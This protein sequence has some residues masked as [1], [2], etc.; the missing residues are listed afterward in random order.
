[1]KIF[2]NI[3]TTVVLLLSLAIGCANP[4]NPAGAGSDTDAMQATDKQAFKSALEK[5]LKAVSQKDLS[6]L[7]GTLSPKGDMYLVLPRSPITT[8]AKE[9]LATH[10]EW[11]QDTSW[12]FETK[13]IHTDVDAN[14]GI[15]V[16]EVMYKEP[17]RNGKPYFNRMAVSYALRK[18]DGNWYVIHDQACSLEKTGD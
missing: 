9:F 13:I 4:A 2:K 15:A 7:A 17:D 16:V 1:M 12:T 5:H 18:L 14:L 10:E 11:F 3:K 8:T 6:T